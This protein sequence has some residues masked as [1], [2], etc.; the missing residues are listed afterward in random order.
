MNSLGYRIMERISGK[1]SKDS[2]VDVWGLR[3]CSKNKASDAVISWRVFFL[4]Y[5]NNIFYLFYTWTTVFPPSLSYAPLSTTPLPF[6]SSSLPCPPFSTTSLPI[7]SPLS[8]QKGTGLNHT[9]RSLTKSPSY[10]TV[11]HIQGSCIAAVQ[12]S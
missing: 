8:I 3:S 1:R 10:T 5:I 12:A 6:S 4:F 9:A 2:R 7:S 11:T